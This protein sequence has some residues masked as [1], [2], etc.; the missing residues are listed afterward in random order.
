MKLY[1]KPSATDSEGRQIIYDYIVVFN[2]ILDDHELAASDSQSKFPG[3]AQF[4]SDV[5][6]ILTNEF[7]CDVV[8]AEESNRPEDISISI[9]FLFTCPLDDK[10]AI[11]CAVFL[12]VS[13]HLSEG[14]YTK[15]SKEFIRNLASEFNM[16]ERTNIKDASITVSTQVYRNYI[17]SLD[18]VREQMNDMIRAWKRR[19]LR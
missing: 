19:Y 10:R 1:K 9:Y 5:K 6:N 3:R 11:R 14:S 7:N 15:R 16:I 12:K 8:Y 17:A 13:D 18:E 4:L 2:F